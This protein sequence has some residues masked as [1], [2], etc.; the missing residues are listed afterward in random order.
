M[1]LM[2]T[3]LAEIPLLNTLLASVKRWPR[4]VMRLVRIS[5]IYEK[6]GELILQSH[7]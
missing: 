3:A 7:T 4:F 5:G 2:F 6:P 1:R